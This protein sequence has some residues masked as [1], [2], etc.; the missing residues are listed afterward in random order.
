MNVLTEMNKGLG[1]LSAH[2]AQKTHLLSAYEASYLKMPRQK[3]SDS[4]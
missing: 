2:I 3:A 4:G 1:K